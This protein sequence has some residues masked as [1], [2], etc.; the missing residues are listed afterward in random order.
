M[1]LVPWLL[2]FLSASYTH[3]YH[4]YYSISST[5]FA[6]WDARPTHTHDDRESTKCVCVCVC[7]MRVCERGCGCGSLLCLLHEEHTRSIHRGYMEE[8]EKKTH[9]KHLFL[10]L[11]LLSCFWV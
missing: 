2:V 6:G 8:K 4:Q 7:G 3:Y 10:F 9:C 5:A 11:F 1:V